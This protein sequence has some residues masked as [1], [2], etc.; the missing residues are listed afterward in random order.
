MPVV[1]TYTSCKDVWVHAHHPANIFT[2]KHV[3]SLSDC[4]LQFLF[5]LPGCMFFISWVSPFH[6]CAFLWVSDWMFIWKCVCVCL[7]W[8]S[9]R[10][11]QQISRYWA[12]HFLAF[13]CYCWTFCQTPAQSQSH[14]KCVCVLS[15]RQGKSVQAGLVFCF[16]WQ[17]YKTKKKGHRE[18]CVSLR[19]CGVCVCVGKRLCC[20]KKAVVMPHLNHEYLNTNL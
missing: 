14:C 6:L 16:Y 12:S 1:A 19:P 9:E 11:I 7:L 17:V 10:P 2:H 8:Q 5:S 15:N 20:T 4:S 18:M 13:A 3:P